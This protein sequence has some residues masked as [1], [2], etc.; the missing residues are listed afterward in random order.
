MISLEYILYPYIINNVGNMTTGNTIIDA[1]LIGL[2]V[3]IIFTVDTRNFKNYIMRKF[4]EKFMIDENNTITF[5]NESTERSLRFK[6]LMYYLSKSNSF[7]SST[8]SC[9]VSVEMSSIFPSSSCGIF[10]SLNGSRFGGISLSDS[11]YCS[12]SFCPPEVR[13]AEIKF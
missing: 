8:R 13:D 1:I 12:I 4:K 11:A 2:F 6:S 5:T 7:E 10:E 9:K 3:I